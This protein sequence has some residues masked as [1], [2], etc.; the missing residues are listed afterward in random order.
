MFRKVSFSRK[1]E[2]L[3]IPTVMLL[4]LESFYSELHKFIFC[5]VRLEAQLAQVSQKFKLTK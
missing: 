2:P 5:S 3:G 4:R 1:N